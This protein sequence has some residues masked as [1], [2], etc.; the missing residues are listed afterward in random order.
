MGCEEEGHPAAL[1][2]VDQPRP[3][4]YQVLSMNKI[5]PLTIQIAAE[6]LCDSGLIPLIVWLAIS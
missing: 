5:R 4:P 3:Q 1:S 6:G 2:L